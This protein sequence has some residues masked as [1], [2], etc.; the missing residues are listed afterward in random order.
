LSINGFEGKVFG[1]TQPT[2][3][4]FKL[5]NGEIYAI[6]MNTEWKHTTKFLGSTLTKCIKLVPHFK[7]IESRHTE[8]VFCNFKYRT[9]AFGLGFKDVFT[10]DG[11]LS[12]VSEI[13]VWGCGSDSTLREQQTQKSRQRMAAERN[14]KVPLPGQWD[15]NPDKA[16]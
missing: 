12:N 3:S 14:Q 8:P 5:N 10:V 11:E 7:F 9:A 15:D 6:A 1:Y 13:E 16:M 2:V 4:I